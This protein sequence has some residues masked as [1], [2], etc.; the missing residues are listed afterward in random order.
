VWILDYIEF[1]LM[2]TRAM[3]PGFFVSRL[4]RLRR[5]GGRKYLLPSFLELVISLT[6]LVV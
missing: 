3:R 4:G 5:Q 2:I 1:F 6:W